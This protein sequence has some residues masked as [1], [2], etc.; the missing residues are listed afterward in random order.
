MD[1][2]KEF[3]LLFSN[4]NYTFNVNLYPGLYTNNHNEFND[5][6]EQ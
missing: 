4:M 3:I 6:K 2:T 5:Q 1:R